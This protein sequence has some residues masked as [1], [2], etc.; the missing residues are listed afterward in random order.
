M[1][2]DPETGKLSTTGEFIH[3]TNRPESIGQYVSLGC[4]RMDNETIKQLASEV[5]RGDIVIIK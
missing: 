2:V 4:M 1:K 5:K 3:G